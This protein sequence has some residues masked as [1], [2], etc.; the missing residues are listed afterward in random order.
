[1]AEVNYLNYAGLQKYDQL[2]K[3]SYIGKKT[4]LKTTEKTT[5][6]AAVN[7][8]YDAIEDVDFSGKAD[9]VIGATEGNFASLDA[10]G[11]LT[12]SGKKAADLVVSIDEAAG[13]GDILKTYTFYQGEKS[14]ATKIGTISLAKDLV[15]T[16]GEV[17]K[18][19]EGQPEGTYLKLTIANQT[20]P[21]YI[22]VADLVD[23]Y[24][25]A[26][27]ATQ[28]QVAISETNVISATLVAGG[29]GTTELATKAVTTE[30]LEDEIVTSLGKADSA[31]QPEDLESI[32]LTGENS[33]EALFA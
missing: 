18:N 9:K 33:I 8:L 29:V 22:N 1:M 31:V 21:V 16:G 11:N 26:A 28:V 15:V 30:K 13:V 5:V 32:P 14:E 12:D 20:N 7:E 27:E 2:M 24:T 19:P 23:A 3:E 17:V 10:E 25:P 6:V 4:D